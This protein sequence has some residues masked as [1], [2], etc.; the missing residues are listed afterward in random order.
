MDAVW[1]KEDMISNQK[2]TLEVQQWTRPWFYLMM[3]IKL[4]SWKFSTLLLFHHMGH[5]DFKYSSA[6]SFHAMK[7]LFLYV[8]L[9]V[10][11]CVS[12]PVFI[13]WFMVQRLAGD[14]TVINSGFHR[15]ALPFQTA[16]DGNVCVC[17]RV[18]AWVCVWV[19]GAVLF[20]CLDRLAIC[21][22]PGQASKV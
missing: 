15:T 19:G 5:I 22:W 3:E 11:L 13:T 20:F 6:V 10:Y 14:A 12:F 2:A 9:R 4:V 16:S 1:T 21:L 17:M 7:H 8:W 18:H